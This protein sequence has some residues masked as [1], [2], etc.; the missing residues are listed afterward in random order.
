MQ[1]RLRPRASELVACAAII[2]FGIAGMGVA[3]GYDLGSVRQMGPGFFPV[4]TCV[5]IVLLAVA[6][7]AETILQ[8]P[9]HHATAWRPLVFIS[10][11]VIVWAV[12]IDREGLMPATVAMIFVSA[13]AR[14]PFKPVA[15]LL[16]SAGI[17]SSGYL[18]F[19]EGLRMPLSFLGR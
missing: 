2:L 6:T 10:S 3:L 12:L 14:P 9:R 16:L 13:L 17:C 5:V 19:I 11:S 8:P 7:A 18:I 4:A 15:L 1:E